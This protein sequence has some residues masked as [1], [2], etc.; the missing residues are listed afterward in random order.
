MPVTSKVQADVPFSLKPCPIDSVQERMGRVECDVDHVVDG[1]AEARF[2]ETH[3]QRE[4]TEK[5]DIRL[6]FA[7]RLDRLLRYLEPI[8]SV[9]RLKFLVLEERSRRKDIIGVVGRISEK[10]F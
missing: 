9:C 8:V 4:L 1:L 5:I 2:T 7:D 10:L 6:R 3:A